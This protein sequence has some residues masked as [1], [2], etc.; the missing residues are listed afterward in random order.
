[1]QRQYMFEASPGQDWKLPSVVDGFVHRGLAP[2]RMAWTVTQDSHSRTK[3][4]LNAFLL[5]ARKCGCSLNKG[6]HI[7]ILC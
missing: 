5:L 2:R 6:P 1:M 7:F 3:T 4:W